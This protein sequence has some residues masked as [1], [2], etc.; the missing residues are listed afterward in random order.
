M[1]G[2]KS[3]AKMHENIV[4]QNCIVMVCTMIMTG[5]FSAREA[6]DWASKLTGSDDTYE[7]LKEKY[8][9]VLKG[10]QKR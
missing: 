10:L 2:L 4:A 6:G 5:R 1:L 3:M 9:E 7:L 8:R